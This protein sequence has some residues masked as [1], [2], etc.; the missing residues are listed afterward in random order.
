MADAYPDFLG[1]SFY[2][3]SFCG[4]DDDDDDDDDSGNDD[5]DMSLGETALH[6]LTNT[7]IEFDL[8]PGGGVTVN[9][10]CSGS[11]CHGNP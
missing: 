5:D 2:A 1:E 11:G 3:V 6:V 9:P 4:G 7:D 10:Q 8:R